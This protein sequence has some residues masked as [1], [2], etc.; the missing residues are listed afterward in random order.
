MSLANVETFNTPGAFNKAPT[1]GAVL[2]RMEILAG[3]VGSLRDRLQRLQ[4][5]IDGGAPT[6]LAP[7]DPMSGLKANLDRI[8]NDMRAIVRTMNSLEELL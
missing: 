8:E 7:S 5:R 4:V 3:E 6:D 1:P 2:K